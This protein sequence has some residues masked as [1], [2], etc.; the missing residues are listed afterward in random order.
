[1]AVR[2]VLSHVK[3]HSDG[4]DG[5]SGLENPLLILS[6]A[7]KTTAAATAAATATATKMHI[8]IIGKS[9]VSAS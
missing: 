5:D 9:Y 2:C 4:G 6:M 8:S 1:M 7:R 3:L